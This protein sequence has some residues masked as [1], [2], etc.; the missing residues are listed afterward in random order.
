MKERCDCSASGSLK[1]NKYAV[2]QKHTDAV[3]QKKCTSLQCIQLRH[4]N[5][6]AN[7]QHL[8]SNCRNALQGEG[9]ENYC[10]DPTTPFTIKTLACGAGIFISCGY[11]PYIHTD[12][13][14]E[15]NAAK[16]IFKLMNCVRQ[17]HVQYATICILCT[18][19]CHLNTSTT[20]LVNIES[21]TLFK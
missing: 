20:L 12:M 6:H 1:K 14:T 3:R 16:S 10:S 5:T 9:L 11:Q 21:S 19:Q 4:T 8:S 15:L 18:C 17:K 7:I 2:M 13:Q